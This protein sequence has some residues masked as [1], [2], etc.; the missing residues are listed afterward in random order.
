MLVKDVPEAKHRDLDYLVDQLDW[1][2]NVDP[3]FKA[4]NYLEPIVHS[5][6]E[7]EGHVDKWIVYGTVEGEQVFSARELTVF[8]GGSCTIRDPGASGLVATQGSGTIGKLAI[9]TPVFIRFG[10]VTKDEVFITEQAAQ[11]GIT[12]KNTGAE[13]FVTL[14]YF[15]PGVH[16]DLPA[17]GDYLKRV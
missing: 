13:P 8:P 7:A 9:D 12:Y 14:R 10:E 16:Q 11:A 15:G 6:S 4:N 2:K 5:G 17:I 3:D 1:E